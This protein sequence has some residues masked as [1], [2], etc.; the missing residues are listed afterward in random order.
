MNKTFLV[1]RHEII[2]TLRSTIYVIFA[3][4][5]P[6]LAVLILG[7][8]KII[9][10]RSVNGNNDGEAISSTQPHLEVE[11][12]ID[13]SGLIQVIPEE[14]QNYLIR[15]GNEEQAKKALQSDNISAY[16]I[17]PSDYLKMGKVYYVYPDTKPYLIKGQTWVIAKTLMFNLLD[18]DL[19]LMDISWN[20]IR[21][22]ETTS[23]A[24]Q[25][26][27]NGLPGED[28]SRPGVSCETNDLVR[29]I[30]LFM[31]ALFFAAFM[32]TS[33][34]LFNSIST[35]KESRLM[36][37]L[38]LA[39]SPRQ[40]F[41]GK[42]LGMGVAGFL[43]IAFWLSAFY[44]SFNSGGSTLN[45]PENF[46][47][48]VHLL[49]WGLVYFLGGYGL[50]AN[51]MA[52]AGAMVPKMKEAGI[53]NY[54]VISPLFLGYLFGFLAALSNTSNTSFLVFLSIFP[55]TSPVVMI[56]RLTAGFVPPWQLISSILLLFFTG[57]FTLNAIASMFHAQNLLS[58]QP[59][60]LKRY[61]GAMFGR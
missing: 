9:Q 47:F 17:I 1:M 46:S 28:C 6:V 57:Y 32:T 43:Q 48:P 10:S 2:N 59:F 11:G 24:P 39:I 13:Q 21:Y 3:F 38:L 7:V 20:P 31:V 60:S 56:M 54:I 29:Y 53:A 45:L 16:Y 15:Y 37:I 4:I 8:V 34:M 35:E 58:G 51:L 25:S 26:N 42:I 40:L 18:T 22:Y 44:I 30:P 41:A 36:E 27:T 52:G 23:I 5:L 33:S 14:F 19:R 12:F 49:V 61:F 55:F 50:Y